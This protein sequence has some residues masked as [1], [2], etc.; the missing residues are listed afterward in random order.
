M[1]LVNLT[2]FQLTAIIESCMNAPDV[3]QKLPIVSLKHID[4]VPL[5]I[6]HDV[7]VLQKLYILGYGIGVNMKDIQKLYDLN[8][9]N[10]HVEVAHPFW[11]TVAQANQANFVDS[12]FG[13][14][15]LTLAYKVARSI[16]LQ[17]ERVAYV[18]CFLYLRNGIHWPGEGFLSA[19]KDLFNLLQFVIDG[20]D[21]ISLRGALRNIIHQATNMCTDDYV[22]ADFTI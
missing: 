6:L 19:D 4:A 18:L 1:I 15:S 20:V 14:L 7:M 11:L 3:L 17:H 21:S 12:K 2:P 9:I 8:D 22:S 5:D 10:K 16:K 13:D